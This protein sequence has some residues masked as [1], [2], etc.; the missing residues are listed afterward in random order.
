MNSVVYPAMRGCM[1]SNAERKRI[2]PLGRQEK[3]EKVR[4]NKACSR[5]REREKEIQWVLC[6]TGELS[7]QMPLDV[8]LLK[9]LNM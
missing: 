9:S 7:G 6:D 5:E 3:E 2:L 4:K 1:V 8:T